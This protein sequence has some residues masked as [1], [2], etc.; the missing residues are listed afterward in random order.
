MNRL[1]NLLV[2]GMVVGLFA[3]SMIPQVFAYSESSASFTKA[4][5]EG[6]DY[7]YITAANKTSNDK[8][9]GLYISQMYDINNKAKY[10]YSRAW[11]KG[12]NQSSYVTAT[13]QDDVG[14]KI[15]KGTMTYVKLKSAFQHKG[16]TIKYFAKGNRPDLDAKITGVLYAD[17]K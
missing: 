10:T 4:Y 16:K 9:V 5:I 1:K 2:T 15:T 17:G 14:K 11:F 12:W 8:Y 3:S 6:D 7:C 13:N